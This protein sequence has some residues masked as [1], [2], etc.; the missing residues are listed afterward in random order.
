MWNDDST[1]FATS[2][3]DSFPDLLPTS[4]EWLTLEGTEGEDGR[5]EEKDHQSRI[6]LGV[7]HQRQSHL[8]ITFEAVSSADVG[9]T[10]RQDAPGRA[11]DHPHR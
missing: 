4:A 5:G 6:V 2:W 3:S 11:T 7:T 10:D 9:K 8:E 1:L